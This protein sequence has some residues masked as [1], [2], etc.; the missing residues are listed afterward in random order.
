[1][2]N[3]LN[4]CECGNGNC[5]NKNN[6]KSRGIAA[7]IV[8][9]ILISTIALGAVSSLQNNEN[10]QNQNTQDTQ[11]APV[12]TNPN[13][14]IVDTL[15]IVDGHP[16]GETDVTGYLVVKKENIYDEI[17][18][19]AYFALSGKT[20]PVLTDWMDDLM[21]K[22]NTTNVIDK[23][24][25]IGIGCDTGNKIKNFWMKEVVGDEYTQLKAST[26]T[27]P[28]NVKLI[29]TNPPEAGGPC[30]SYVKEMKF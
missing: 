5:C 23:Y 11:A 29:F 21:G 25:M 14:A 22:G 27:N 6:G 30:L 9:V 26:E 10:A 20:S 24:H 7:I 1:M 2:K 15:K 17:V 13:G 19:S 12:E 18:N 8:V 3:N 16:E 28:I 4:G